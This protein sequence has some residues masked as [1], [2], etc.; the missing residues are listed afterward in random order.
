[1]V[2]KF[3]DH[4]LWLVVYPIIYGVLYIQTVVGNG[5]SEPSTAAPVFSG[6][7][8]VSF[9]KCITCIMFNCLTLDVFKAWRGRAVEGARNWQLVPTQRGANHLEIQPLNSWSIHYL[10][11]GAGFRFISSSTLQET[12]ISRISPL[13]VAGKMGFPPRV[14]GSKDH[15][16]RQMAF[17][18]LVSCVKFNS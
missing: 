3:G 9:R 7:F 5:I 4:Q 15:S 6:A 13:K 2:Q 12:N 11:S 18:I 14:Y 1:M 17:M 10:V 8:A 16:T